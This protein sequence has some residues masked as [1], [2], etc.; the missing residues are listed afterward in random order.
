MDRYLESAGRTISAKHASQFLAAF[1]ERY[2][3]ITACAS[4]AHRIAAANNIAEVPN[5]YPADHARRVE[6][7]AA[8]AE[9][10]SANET[11][12]DGLDFSKM[13]KAQIEAAVKERAGV[14]LDRRANKATLIERAKKVLGLA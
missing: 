10:A 7:D 3:D 1:R 8:L 9:P 12:A 5:P 11:E 6:W 14:D 2:P 13:T 4:A